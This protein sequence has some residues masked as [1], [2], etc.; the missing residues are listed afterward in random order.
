MK[1]NG[2]M[3]LQFICL[4]IVHETW[5]SQIKLKFHEAIRIALFRVFVNVYLKGIRLN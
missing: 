5:K 4:L 2:K 3:Y 1:W